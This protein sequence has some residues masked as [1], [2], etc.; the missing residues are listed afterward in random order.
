VVLADELLLK[1]RA[2]TKGAEKSVTGFAEHTRTK[3]KQVSQSFTN[4]GRSLT[5]KLTLPIVGL[6][7]VAVKKFFAQEV[8][9]AKLQSSFESMGAS[10]WT[11]MDALQGLADSIQATSTFG[12][13]AVESM[14]AVLLT[15]GQIKNQ[16]EGAN[17]VFDRTTQ[18]T[19][20]MAALME[21]DLQSAAI[22]LGKALNDP[23]ANLG[24]LS[25]SGVQ[26]TAD[27][28][29]LIKGLWES[30]DALG[31][32]KVILEELERQFGGT[33]EAVANTA[34]GKWQ[35]AM[36]KMGDSMEIVG[37][38]I[39]PIVVE[40]ADKISELAVSFDGL[41]EK[42]QRLIVGASG[43]AA[44]IGPLLLVLGNAVKVLTF[45]T[46]PIG[47]IIAAIAGVVWVLHQMGVE[48]EDVVSWIQ[49]VFLPTVQPILEEF[50]AIVSEVL[51]KVTAWFEE[52][53][54]TIMEVVEKG[55]TFLMDTWNEIWA[56]IGPVIE[57]LV[58]FAVEEIGALIQWFI[59]NWPR[60]Q[61][62]IEKVM[63]IIQRFWE[64]IWGTISEFIG[65]IFDG[66]MRTISG[67]LDIIKG[68]IQTV[69]SIITGDWGAAWDGIKQAV[70]G[71]WDAIN[72]A[73]DTAWQTLQATWDTIIS[74]LGLAWDTFWGG[75]GEG[76]SAIGTAVVDALKGVINALIGALE[77]G[78]NF[79]LRGLQKAID[80]ADVI[81]GPFVNFPDEMFTPISIPRLA[82]GGITTSDG[83]VRVGE[84]GI[85]VLNLPAG[86]SVQPL[87][88]S[89]GNGATVYIDKMMGGDPKATAD[90]IGWEFTKRGVA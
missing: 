51:G 90:E 36:N 39:A 89:N 82:E 53:W 56:V 19:A 62:V 81:A 50:Q 16:G 10:A 70:S 28:K 60:I 5:T 40:V 68:V 23:V 79:A 80:A 45:L 17:A 20:D 75:L 48:W 67:A 25:R 46:T 74:T 26:F 34:S 72:G 32:Q 42:W 7:T 47:L 6:A 57:K 29:E 33:A 64:R 18:V 85:E 78:V 35:Q 41:D 65:P 14:Q 37:G 54:D 4:A 83:P 66:I 61:E 52:N 30:G 8:A 73:V 59:D 12:D 63:G 31:A 87:T 43:G 27:Q 86:T 44:A 21:T 88:G 1:V 71:A 55:A 9:T 24:A 13:E 69:L 76:I 15:F 49:N 84:R 3:M 58:A 11:S 22:M 2:D 77:D 38:I